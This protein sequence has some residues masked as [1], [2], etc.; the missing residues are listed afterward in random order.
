MTKLDKLFDKILQSPK[1][2]RYEELE[3]VLT[4]LGYILRPGKGSHMVFHHKKY[5]EI[6]VPH[7]SP[8][9]RVYIEQVKEV[10]KSCLSREND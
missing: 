8:V 4:N 2:M 9:K 6:T 5:H 10:L 3:R 7:R 1:E